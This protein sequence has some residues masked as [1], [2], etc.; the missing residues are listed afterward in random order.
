MMPR[1]MAQWVESAGVDKS[2]F[3]GACRQLA[4]VAQ[5]IAD[6]ELRGQRS[7]DA[8]VERLQRELAEATR[9]ATLWERNFEGRTEQCKELTRE[10]AKAPAVTD[11]RL[12]ADLGLL[13]ELVLDYAP[14]GKSYPYGADDTPEALGIAALDRITAA[15]ARGGK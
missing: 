2:G 12:A 6:A 8:E 4:G 10:L 1:F 3:S 7:R 15:L 5:A 9:R 11:E 13:R 14:G